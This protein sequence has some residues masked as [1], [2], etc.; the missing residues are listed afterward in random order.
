MTDEVTQGQESAQVDNQMTEDVSAEAGHQEA[1]EI[2]QLKSTIAEMKELL[3]QQTGRFSQLEETLKPKPRQLSSEEKAALMQENPAA[4]VEAIIEEK[5]GGLTGKIESQLDKKYWDEKAKTE[6][7]VNDPKFKTELQ[8]VWQDLVSAGLD[9]A[10]PRAIYK[11]AELTARQLGGGVKKADV[12]TYQTAEGTREFAAPKAKPKVSE[13]DPR[14]V[15]Y[16]MFT[17]DPKKILE[18]QKELE[19]KDAKRR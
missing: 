8:R 1:N 12:K 5:F 10:H 2:S 18:F 3:A 6:Y 7:P 9:P 14:V 4:A 19:A 16:K 13:N 15:A 17:N 11:A